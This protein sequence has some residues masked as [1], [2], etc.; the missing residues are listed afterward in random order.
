MAK[1]KTLTTK[2]PFDFVQGREIRNA[3]VAACVEMLHYT[4]G[5]LVDVCI[6]NFG[7]HE[8]VLNP[9]VS[10]VLSFPIWINQDI[11][12]LLLTMRSYAPD[13]SGI[14]GADVHVVIGS[15]SA[16]DFTFDNANAGDLVNQSV[17]TTSTGTGLQ[18]VTVTSDTHT[19]SHD[20][21]RIDLLSIY[22]HRKTSDP[23]PVNG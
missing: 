5:A 21:L 3:D 13:Y 2:T 23:D 1:I 17:A 19:G 10:E 11:Q 15:A 12:T 18:F 20:F 8:W 16:I 14:N 4:Q 22:G 9:A 6:N 7:R